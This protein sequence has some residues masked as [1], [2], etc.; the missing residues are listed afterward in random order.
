MASLA[1]FFLGPPG[2]NMQFLENDVFEIAMMVSMHVGRPSQ[3]CR[4]NVADR[5]SLVVGNVLTALEAQRWENL[6]PDLELIPIG[7]GDLRDVVEW[8]KSL[9]LAI[10]RRIQILSL[11]LD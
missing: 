8:L 3:A 2:L 7:L 4:V 10:T 11:H 6:V 5:S 1:S 9:A